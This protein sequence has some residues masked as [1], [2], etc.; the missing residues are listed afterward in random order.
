V[1]SILHVTHLRQGRWHSGIR[2]L[3]CL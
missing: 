3:S 1:P 2:P